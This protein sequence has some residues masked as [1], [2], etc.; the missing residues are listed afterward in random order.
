MKKTTILAMLLWA[1][2]AVGT[3]AQNPIAE[4]YNGPEGY[5]T[6]IN[7]V[8]WDNRITME[9]KNSGA[10]NFAEFKAKRD[11]LYAQGGGVLYYPAGTYIFDIPDG[12]NDEGLMLKKGV[13]ILGATPGE[14]KVAVKGKNTATGSVNLDQRGL[15]SM[16]T[17]FQLSLIHI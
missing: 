6:W 4:F 13:V 5:P 12:P 16:P 2:I 14:D 15:S 10:A 3:N 7:E 8:K 9:N 1:F 11:L 17:K